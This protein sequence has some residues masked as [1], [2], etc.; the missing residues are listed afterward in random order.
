MVKFKWNL[1]FT[2]KSQCHCNLHYVQGR[3]QI[4][5]K[6]GLIAAEPNTA[7]RTVPLLRSYP[8]DH[9]DIR[10]DPHSFTTFAF[11]GTHI[12]RGKARPQY[13]CS[14]SVLLEVKYAVTV[15]S[16]EHDV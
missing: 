11:P 15:S 9:P 7:W 8:L 5:V 1:N 3:L 2:A 4:A 12:L 16:P 13:A 10:L 6:P 14:I